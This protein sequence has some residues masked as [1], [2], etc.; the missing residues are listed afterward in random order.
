MLDFNLKIVL[1][2]LKIKCNNV[3]YIILRDTK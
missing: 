1:Q 3:L 2:L